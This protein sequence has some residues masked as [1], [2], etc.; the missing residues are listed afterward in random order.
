LAYKNWITCLIHRSGAQSGALISSLLTFNTS[1][2]VNSRQSLIPAFQNLLLK[3]EFARG[4][5]CR[6]FARRIWESSQKTE[7]ICPPRVWQRVAA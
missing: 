5:L 3:N 1:D 7:K 2:F 4:F 6:Q